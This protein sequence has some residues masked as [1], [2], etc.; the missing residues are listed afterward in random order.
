MLVTATGYED[1]F[2]RPSA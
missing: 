1:A 2:W